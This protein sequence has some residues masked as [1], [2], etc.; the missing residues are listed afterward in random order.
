VRNDIRTGWHIGFSGGLGSM[1]SSV[2]EFE[3]IDC[4]GTP[5]TMSFE[6]HVG[7]MI[8]D[9]MAVQGEVWFHSRALDAYGDASV[10]QS[11]FLLAAQYWITPRF[12]GK[13]G[14][15]SSSFT[16]NYDGMSEQLDTGPGLMASLGYELVHSKSF[17]LDV[18]YKTGQGFYSDR[19]EEVGVH[20][21]Q[22][23][24]NWY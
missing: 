22:L 16:L 5:P 17:G 7:S 23:G 8:S 2:G 10:T 21:V 13:L 6:L 3:C 4:D 24:V 20:T 19:D 1:E 14:L 12:W 15:G 18:L 11:M 9:R